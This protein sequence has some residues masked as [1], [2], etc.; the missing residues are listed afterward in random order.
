VALNSTCL[1][2]NPYG[3]YIAPLYSLWIS[4][5]LRNVEYSRIRRITLHIDIQLDRNETTIIFGEDVKFGGVFRCCVSAQNISFI[6]FLNSD[7][8][9]MA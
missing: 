8:F 6:F 2:L 9:R 3:F 7:I 1:S 5:N 4:K